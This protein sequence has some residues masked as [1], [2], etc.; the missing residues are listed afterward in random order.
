MEGG[1]SHE[2]YMGLHSYQRAHKPGR[3]V[4]E[5]RDFSSVTQTSINCRHGLKFLDAHSKA[6]LRADDTSKQ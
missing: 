1:V 4:R 3:V 5:V 6:Q 2:W